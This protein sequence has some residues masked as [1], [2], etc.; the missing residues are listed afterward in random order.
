[1][2]KQIISFLTEEDIAYLKKWIRKG[3]SAKVNPSH[4]R[5]REHTQRGPDCYLVKLPVEGLDA[6]DKDTGEIFGADCDIFKFNDD[7]DNLENTDEHTKVWNPYYVKWYGNEDEEEDVLLRAWRHKGGQ[8]LCEKPTY[9]QKVKPIADI[10]PGEDGECEIVIGN[11]PLEEETIVVMLR[12][13]A[14]GVPITAGREASAI[15]RETELIW[16]FD[17]ESCEEVSP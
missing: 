9:H 2:A 6:R 13:M 4:K 10:N 8:Y 14:A 17:G 11:T 3:R 16:E 7:E 15:F 12:W 5:Y 1:M